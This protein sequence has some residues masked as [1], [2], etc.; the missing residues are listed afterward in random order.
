MNTLNSGTVLRD[1]YRILEL[2]R[3]HG[4]VNHYVADKDGSRVFIKEIFESAVP[5]HDEREARREEFI[6]H[7]ERVSTIDHPRMARILDFFRERDRHY[8]IFEFCGGVTLYQQALSWESKEEEILKIGFQ[9]CEAL[10]FI[11]HQMS[12][13]MVLRVLSP[14]NVLVLPDDS[15]RIIDFGITSFFIPLEE[16]RYIFRQWGIPGFAS[17][18]QYGRGRVDARADIYSFGALLY[19]LCTRQIPPESIDIS[20]G[21]EELKSPSH[22]RKTIH[23]QL[24]RIILRSMAL[25]PGDRH[26][27]FLEVERELREIT[28]KTWSSVH[29]HQEGPHAPPPPVH[30][31]DLEPYRQEEIWAVERQKKNEL[32]ISTPLGLDIGGSSIKISAVE[33]C[34]EGITATL[35]AKLPV[36]A[37]SVVNGTIREPEKLA[38]HL[39]AWLEGRNFGSVPPPGDRLI[40]K[41]VASTGL[42]KRNCVVMI[43]GPELTIRGFETD[44][45]D[46]G[47]IRYQA[48]LQLSEGSR[49]KAHSLRIET[50]LMRKVK[51]KNRILFFAVPA[52]T[53]EMIR[54]FT[55]TLNF[56]LKAIECEPVAL[57]RMLQLI[58]GSERPTRTI[59]LLNIGADYSCLNFFGRGTIAHSRIL[60]TGGNTFNEKLSGELGISTGKAERLKREVP[61]LPVD[62]VR[63]FAS[64]LSESLFR[65]VE[66]ILSEYVKELSRSFNYYSRMADDSKVELLF[67]TGGGALLTN[68]ERYLSRK[69]EISTIV[70][71]V[72]RNLHLSASLEAPELKKEFAGMA[73]TLG[74]SCHDLFPLEG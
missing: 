16:N 42:V 58:L 66:P 74:M 29:L 44:S 34:R 11:N 35:L 15:V 17:P 23:P 22:F 69:L 46:P 65:I 1:T 53:V 18:E 24:E 6:S 71:D 19:F 4:W 43:G 14:G 51:K 72:F 49:I 27:S 37:G 10:A 55:N 7:L 73:S 60:T 25:K 32:G 45:T 63:D 70:G 57:F 31:P 68:L 9:I 12:K 41:L 64:S 8:V 48:Q 3:A 20:Q 38:S 67:I 33:R 13:P 59:A 2:K 61:L 5:A 50:I 39:K 54:E 26:E 36:P 28:R 40:D 47:E 30:I 21:S 62:G 56:T 52:E